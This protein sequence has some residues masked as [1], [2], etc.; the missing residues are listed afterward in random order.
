M[1]TIRGLDLSGTDI[2]EVK[3]ERLV[4]AFYTKVRTDPRLGPIFE[5]RLGDDWEPHLRRMMDFWSSLMLTTGR[6]SGTPLQKHLQLGDVRSEDFERWLELFEKTAVSV[7][8][9]AFAAAFMNK[10]SRVEKSL[11]MAMVEI[12]SYRAV[13]GLDAN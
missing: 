7:G 6:Y 1:T 11:Q 12:G 4:R 13:E 2:D 8:G 5:E 10:A 9:K 3:I